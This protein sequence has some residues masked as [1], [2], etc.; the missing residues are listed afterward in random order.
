[1]SL[2]GFV[3]DPAWLFDLG[4]QVRRWDKKVERSSPDS[5]DLANVYRIPAFAPLSESAAP[6]TT[7]MAWSE[8]EILLCVQWQHEIRMSTP[9]LGFSLDFYI[10]TRS[11]RGIH[12]AN[13]YCHLFQFRF[14][15]PFFAPLK[16][17]H[18]EAR[19]GL[20]SRAKAIA[21]YH[22]ANQVS[23]WFTS[24]PSLIEFK[25]LVPYES[26]VGCNPVEFPEWG[27]MWVANDGRKRTSLA[28]NPIH[29]PLDDPSLWC[30]AR[31]VDS[32]DA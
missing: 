12:R 16:S 30:C 9:D 15:Q 5:W 22:Q 6:S 27:V 14:R 25:I 17:K 19:P 18:L 7:W 8:R 26:L 21:A 1:M 24:T 32:S 31:L 11:S 2:K 13:A 3:S 4:F 23:G 20:I 29:I 28:R 10:D